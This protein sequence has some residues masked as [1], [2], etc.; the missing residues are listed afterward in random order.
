MANVLGIVAEYNPF[1]N[2][3]LYHLEKSKQMTNSEYT[4]CV[5][6]GNFVQRGQ[7]ALIDKWTR[8]KMCLENGIDLVI[9]LPT[10]YATSS[11]ENFAYG[12]MKILDSLG[13]VDFLSFGSENCDIDILNNIATV[14]YEEPKQFS[15]LLAHELKKG[16]SFPKARENALLMYMNNIKKYSNILNKPNNILGIEYL[17]ALKEIKSH[18]I[19]FCVKREK[20]YYNSQ[21]IVDEY[22]S[23]T[24]I[25][26][27]LRRGI[28]DEIRPVMPDSSYM[29]LGEQVDK[30]NFTINL[31]VFEKEII[32]KLRTMKAEEIANL[33]DVSEGLEFAIKNASDNCNNLKDL[34]SMI[35]SKRYT[36]SRIQRILV[37][38]LL[39]ITKKDMEISKRIT[40]YVRILGL[41]E[42]GKRLLSSINKINPKIKIVTSPKKFLD[43]M[44]VN[45]NLKTM[46]EKDIEATNIYTL[47]YNDSKANLDYTQKIIVY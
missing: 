8:T 12:A 7:T 10:I 17:K 30:G 21:H 24:A 27:L 16:I 13:V 26:E 40:P 32:Y 35:K 45:K 23:A 37:Y 15:G 6:S 9:E 36:Q 39:N 29:M 2:G 28:F 43:S 11:S 5:M 22:A 47:G 44:S 3:H 14:F 19:P 1:H 34:V 18:I 46:L 42:K 4:I 31:A 33:P 38:C 25:R 20:V 41:N